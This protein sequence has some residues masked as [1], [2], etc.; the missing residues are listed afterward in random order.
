MWALVV[1]TLTVAWSVAMAREDVPTS[2]LRIF[3]HGFELPW[4][5]VLQKTAAA[6]MPALAEGGSPLALFVLTGAILWV[7][8][9]RPAAGARLT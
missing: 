3:V 7:I 6:Y 2:L 1:P 8:W 5:T 9:S 4:H